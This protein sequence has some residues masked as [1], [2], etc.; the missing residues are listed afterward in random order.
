MDVI[1][2][3]PDCRAEHAEPLE[4]VLGHRARCATCLMLLEVQAEQRG[5]EAFE[6]PVAA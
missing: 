3:C 2:F 1:Y 5:A 4:A 6:I